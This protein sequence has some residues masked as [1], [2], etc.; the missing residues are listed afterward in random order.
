MLKYRFIRQNQFQSFYCLL[1]W[2]EVNE[3]FEIW[4]PIEISKSI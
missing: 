3:R 4:N 2:H 1:Q